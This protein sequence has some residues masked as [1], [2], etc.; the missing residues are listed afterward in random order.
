MTQIVDDMAN[1]AEAYLQMWERAEGIPAPRCRS[2]TSNVRRKGVRFIELGLPADRFL[3]RAGQPQQRDGRVWRWCLKQRAFDRKRIT[4][5]LTPRGRSALIAT[6]ARAQRAGKIGVGDAERRVAGRANRIARNLWTKQAGK[7]RRFV[8][9]T[10]RG[11]VT[12][13]A[14]ATRAAAKDLRTLQQYLRLGGL[15]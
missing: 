9:G 13:V 14:V 15:R 2:R 10:R 7:G 5:V 11:E 3:R 6:N 4:A 12:F 1:G 8:Y